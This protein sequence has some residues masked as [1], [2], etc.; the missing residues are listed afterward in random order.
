MCVPSRVKPPDEI[1][2][3]RPMFFSGTVTPWIDSE[4]VRT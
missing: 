1:A 3:P 4:L 2:M